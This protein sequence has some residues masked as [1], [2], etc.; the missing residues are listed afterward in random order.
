MYKTYKQHLDQWVR[1]IAA[2]APEELAVIIMFELSEA[3]ADGYNTSAVEDGYTPYP[4]ERWLILNQLK[5]LGLVPPDAVVD[6]ESK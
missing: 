4:K 6:E 2:M 3:W 1:K 5:E